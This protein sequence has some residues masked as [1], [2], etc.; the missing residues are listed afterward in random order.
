MLAIGRRT[1]VV[2]ALAAP[3]VALA[4]GPKPSPRIGVLSP[5]AEASATEI[6]FVQELQNYGYVLGQNVF[7]DYKGAAENAARLNQLAAELVGSKVDVI[8]AS[9]SQATN[10]A[11]RQTSSIP[12]VTMSTNPVGLGFV[13]SLA[14]PGGNITGI[15]L[16]GPEVAGKRFELLKELVPA[17]VSVAIVWNPNDP[18]A[19]FSLT[20][21]QS[22][23]RALAVNLIILETRDTAD[24]DG[25]FLAA[26]REGASA[27]ILLPAPI[28]NSSAPRIAELALQSRLPTLFFSDEGVK[29]SGLASYGANLVASYRR[30]A[31]YV[32]RVLKGEKPSDLPIEQPTEFD[33]AINLKTAK[34]LGLKIPPTLLARADEVIECFPSSRPARQ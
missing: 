22:A 4:Q 25:A 17:I 13:A 8:F 28:T 18:G 26:T 12:I 5:N 11:R 1:L 27:V 7:V 14:H 32:D 34:A 9:G 10:A 16:L 15:S 2:A 33:F 20:E 31:F 3:F 21:T 29:A 19:Q 30:A 24:F 6:A 23:G